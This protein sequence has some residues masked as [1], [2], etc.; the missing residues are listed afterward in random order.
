MQ[1]LFLGQPLNAAR[2]AS[3]AAAVTSALGAARASLTDANAVALA[4]K[5]FD[6][7]HALSLEQ[8]VDGFSAAK[9]LTAAQVRNVAKAAHRFGVE[10][11]AECWKANN[12]HPVVLILDPEIQVGTGSKD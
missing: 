1:A 6:A 7:A 4:H 12:R 9:D 11:S 5:L 3:V 10:S 8:L 2:T